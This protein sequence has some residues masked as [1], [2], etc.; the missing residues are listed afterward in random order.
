M[1]MSFQ[2]FLLAPVAAVVGTLTLA[3]AAYADPA[4]AKAA[5][6]AAKAQGVVGEKADGFLGLVTGT[7]DDAVKA[8]V[9]EINAGRS[10]LYAQAAAKNGVTP[11]AAGAS[12]FKT[13]VQDRL[14]AGEYYQTPAGVWVRK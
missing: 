11:A 8:A 5:V 12:A 14:K 3:G 4:A 1:T 6:D 9:A 7:A 13:V 10:Q 2:N